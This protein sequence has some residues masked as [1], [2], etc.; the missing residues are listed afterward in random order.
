[1]ENEVLQTMGKHSSSFEFDN[2]AIFEALPSKAALIDAEGEIINTNSKWDREPN[3]FQW[4]GLKPISQNYFK[5]CERAVKD[6]NDYALKVIFGLRDILDMKKDRFELTAPCLQQKGRCWF[7]ITIAPFQ[8]QCALVLFEDVSKNM[9]SVQSLRESEEIYS[10][11]FRNSL[12]GIILGTPNGEIIDV[13]PAACKILGY[14]REELLQG[15]R[16]LIADENKPVNKKANAIRAKKSMYEG[17]KE[18]IHKN[19]NLLSVEVSSVL[20]RNENGDLRVVNTF[21]DKSKEKSTLQ[22]LKEERGFTEAVINSTPNVFFV[23]NTEFEL[24][25]WNKAFE[26]ELGYDEE[27]IKQ[28]KALDYFS[29]NDKNRVIKV[30]KEAFETGTGHIIAE[31]ISKKKGLRHFHFQANSFS[32]NGEDFLVGTA[33]DITDMIEIEN[34][35]DKNYELISQ[36]FE[37][38][39][40]GMVMLS[41]ESKIMKVNDSFTSLFGYNKLELIGEN[42]SERIVPKEEKDTYREFCTSV[43]EGNNG[44]AEVIRHTKDGDHLNIIV[45]AVP[46]WQDNKVVAA[47]AIYVDLTEQKKLESRIQKS[48]SEKEVL[49][50]E[51]HHRVK[52]NL[53]IIAG[54]L[55]LQIME[56]EDSIIENKLNEVRS[57]IFSIAKI[58]ETLYEKEDVVHIR[59]DK[60]LETVMNA[61]PQMQSS[62]ANVKMV[63]NLEEVTLNLNQAVPCGLAINE[64][65][66]IIFSES[67]LL[68]ELEIELTEEKN[69]IKLTLM[70]DQ[71]NLCAIDPM[72]ESDAFQ[73]RLV[74]I[75][76]SQIHGSLTTNR[77]GVKKATLKFKKVNQRG[78]S[79]SV[80]NPNELIIN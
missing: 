32:N 58:H 9:R 53:A 31:V 54:L 24:V 25:R 18:Y 47:Y 41:K 27:F 79:S 49:L 46:I 61:L 76:L 19:G 60:Y 20:Y 43:F 21:R 80:I 3:P 34:E 56:E 69:E 68:N 17:E 11:H 62:V 70:S 48:L 36:L 16:S 73:N 55:D 74:G 13:N 64:I 50:Q 71:L 52:N 15:G 30:A 2:G 4:F 5:H 10:Q 33:T 44:K 59:F 40:L 38:S 51:V 22:E 29:E 35:R 63:L 77:E 72:S 37:S 39:P 8:N 65:M 42:L 67:E 45:N 66:N 57:R 14:S 23:L 26:N 6:G 75:F 1:M 28:S 7:K 78:S 12:A